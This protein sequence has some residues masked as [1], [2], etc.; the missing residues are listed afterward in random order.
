MFIKANAGGGSES[1]FVLLGSQT[2]SN[3]SATTV[4]LNSS[5]QNYKY[6]FVALCTVSNS[7]SVTDISTPP[8]QLIKT[9][10]WTSGS[11]V[12]GYYT[13]GS[14]SSRGQVYIDIT[15]VS[16]TSIQFKKSDSRERTLYFYGLK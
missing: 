12:R 6:L 15:Y 14:G 4:S 16:N 3:T 11:T 2:S 8:I 13:I 10:A 5:I 9:S 7:V 1:G